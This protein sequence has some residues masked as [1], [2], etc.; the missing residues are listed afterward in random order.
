[1]DQGSDRGR[2]SRAGDTVIVCDIVIESCCMCQRLSKMVYVIS[3]K[4]EP[5]SKGSISVLVSV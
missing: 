1:M 2:G 4:E 3:L 5:F